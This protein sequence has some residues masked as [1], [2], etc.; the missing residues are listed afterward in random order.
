MEGQI[1]DGNDPGDGV[2]VWSA[3]GVKLFQVD[4]GD[5]RVLS[6]FSL[7]CD[8]GRLVEADEAARKRPLS[9]KWTVAHLDEERLQLTGVDREHDDIDG[10]I[11]VS[12]PVV[13]V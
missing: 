4:I 7:G 1:G 10:H 13:V 2:S 3:E 6:E 9:R 8:I 5:A 12:L 11:G